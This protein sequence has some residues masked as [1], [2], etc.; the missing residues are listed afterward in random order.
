MKKAAVVLI[1]IIMMAP[2]AFPQGHRGKGRVRGFVY[3]EEGNPL[4]GVTVSLFS[5]RGQSGFATVT[6]SKGKWVAAWIRGGKWNI[7]FEL[8]GYEPKKISADFYETKKNPDIEV[9]MK[10]MEGK[11]LTE[12]WMEELENGNKLFDEEKYD[13]A[14]KVYKG[15]L[16]KFPEAYIINKNIGNCYFKRELYD[17]ARLY[18]EKVLEREPGSNEMKLAIGYCLANSG[19]EEKANEWYDSIAFEEINDTAIL[20]NIGVH[21]T[22]LSKFQEALKYYRKAVDIEEDFIDG[23]YQ[24]GLTH[25]TLEQ[26]QE[27]VDAFEKYLVH[28]PDSERA[29]QVRGFIEFLR[30][31]IEK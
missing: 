7:D 14:E 30:T 4:E 19:E 3:D 18:Y 13:E 29:Y 22:E 16:E 23:L 6:D 11:A 1:M 17:T 26:Y 12:D 15:I 20:F 9:Q 2:L 21:Y 5:E 27:A 31:K 8:T 24:L 25:L 10:K 28:D